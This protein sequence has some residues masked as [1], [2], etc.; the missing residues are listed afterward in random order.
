[1]IATLR[2][3]LKA[4]K[5]DHIILDVGGIGFKVHVPEPF[6][7]GLL[8]PGH[9]LELFTHLHFRDNVLALYGMG[10]EEE[11]ALFELLLSVSGV[12][13]RTALSILSH[14]PAEALR[15]AIARE[16]IEAVSKVPGVGPKTAK[17]I[18]F[19]LKDKIRVGMPSLPPPAFI[20][21]DE[22]VI[23]ALTSLGYSLVEAQ[24]AVQSLSVEERDRDIE[25][26]IR[27]ALRYFAEGR[28]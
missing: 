7:D 28:P 1:M 4:R 22:E 25:E 9:E 18:I 19:H 3:K 2:G 11:M 6:L 8:G 16:E 10:S 15:V 21:A 20:A 27:L 14:L 17:K 26:R 12:G 5:E 23:A 24:A 13:P